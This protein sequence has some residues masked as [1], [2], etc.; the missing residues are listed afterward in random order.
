[1][2]HILFLALILTS[3]NLKASCDIFIEKNGLTPK[4]DQIL[5]S[6]LIEKGYSITEDKTQASY[7]LAIS[8]G[9]RNRFNSMWYIFGDMR[10]NNQSQ[11][12]QGSDYAL[13]L[14]LHMLTFTIST[15]IPTQGSV[16][17][18]NFVSKVSA[19]ENN[20][21]PKVIKSEVIKQETVDLTD[22]STNN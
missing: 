6:S 20:E 12:I 19:C 11:F 4:Q 2:K 17:M 7:T 21:T 1:M 3:I 15:F 22:E 16:A 10:L 13:M 9:P 5:T 18:Y 8:S 14:P